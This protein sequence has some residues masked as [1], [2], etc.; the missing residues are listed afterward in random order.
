MLYPRRGP[1]ELVESVTAR[2]YCGS[3]LWYALKM[4]RL[5]FKHPA[6]L[7]LSALALLVACSATEQAT[8]GD[9]EPG[10]DLSEQ[11]LTV[12]AATAALEFSEPCRAGTSLTIAAVGDVLLHS[13]LQIQAYAQGF[14]S[15]WSGVNKLVSR[16]DLSYANL[17]GPTAEGVLASGREARDPGL[18]FD[19]A[20]YSS[21]PMFNYHPSLVNALVDLGVD[22]VSTANNHA[23]DRRGLGADKTIGALRG[24]GLPFSGTRARDNMTAPWSTVTEKDGVKVGWIACSFSTNGIPDPEHQVLNCFEDTAQLLQEVKTLKTK[25]D[26]VIVTPHW[27]AEYVYQPNA[28][29]KKLA[30]QVLDAGALAIFGS[31]PHVVEPWEK[32]T[33][34]DG[35][36]TFVIYSLGNF[37]SGQTPTPRR[38]TLVLYMGITKGQ[39]GVTRINGVRYVPLTMRKWTVEPSDRAASAGETRKLVETLLGKWNQV[40]SDAALTKQLG[41]AR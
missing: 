31:H 13:P 3:S 7:S 1:L 30:R 2:V 18:R 27:G 39:D 14:A 32:Y 5:P 29:Q 28:Q 19:N 11:D 4:A 41:C 8:D 21:Y 26:A 33:T 24:G 37:V 9:E 34:Q 25:V 38:A 15:L 16:A 10:P 12:P 22:V 40:P 23:L 17:E 36:E 20:V 6:F 35:R